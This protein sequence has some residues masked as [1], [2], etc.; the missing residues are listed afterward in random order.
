MNISDVYLTIE[1]LIAVVHS[2][3]SG[4]PPA[5]GS[6]LWTFDVL[7]GEQVWDMH[8]RQRLL[9]TATIFFQGLS[10]LVHKSFPCVFIQ[11]LWQQLCLTN[12]A[13]S[14]ALKSPRHCSLS[15]QDSQPAP[16]TT[17]SW[18]EL[19]EA[20]IVKVKTC[21]DTSCLSSHSRCQWHPPPMTL[22]LWWFR[23]S[24]QKMQ[25]RS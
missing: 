21:Q 19:C 8:E 14:A 23:K 9:L 11:S 1:L 24:E 15:E 3:L 25:K 22:S 17:D 2:K 6:T 18:G 10:N 7:T 16:D 20:L 5:M 4:D 12:H 13:P